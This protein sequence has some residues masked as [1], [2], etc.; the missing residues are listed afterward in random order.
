MHGKLLI[1]GDRFLAPADSISSCMWRRRIHLL[2]AFVL[3]G[4]LQ[5]V[6]CNKLSKRL[7]QT[8]HSIDI[9]T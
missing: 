6:D 4:T 9:D 8:G 1:G 5:V 7:L 3:V 2:F